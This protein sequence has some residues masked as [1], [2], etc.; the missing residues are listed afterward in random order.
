[1]YQAATPELR[2]IM[3]WLEKQFAPGQLR[4]V[5]ALTKNS[6]R[7]VDRHGTASLV[8]CTQDGSVELMD[9]LEAC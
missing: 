6:A 8:I 2:R 5:E 1:M 7:I 3:S 4:R 9:D